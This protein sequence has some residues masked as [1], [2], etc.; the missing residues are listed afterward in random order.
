MNDYKVLKCLELIESLIDD[1][2][3]IYLGTNFKD[4]LDVAFPAIIKFI[5]KVGYGYKDNYHEIYDVGNEIIFD[6]NESGMAKEKYINIVKK[7][8][9]K[10]IW[11][12]N[13]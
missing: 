2:P 6:D 9:E 3:V 4:T 8:F 12:F 5:E 7:L 13:G 10:K 11:S 1:C